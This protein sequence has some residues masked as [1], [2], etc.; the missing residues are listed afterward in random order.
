MVPGNVSMKI[1]DRESATARISTHSFSGRLQS[2]VEEQARMAVE[3]AGEG[4]HSVVSL[5]AAQK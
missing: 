2:R 1:W 5:L 3:A 4:P